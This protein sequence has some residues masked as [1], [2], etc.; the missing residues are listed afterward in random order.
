M[1]KKNKDKYVSKGIHNSVS[2]KNRARDPEPTLF[3]KMRFKWA[4]FLK[5]RKVY[6]TIPNP[7]KEETNKRF[8]RV[9]ARTLYGDYRNY[10]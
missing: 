1:A 10:R 4:A 3:E 2:K 8:I 6:Y 5:G 7:N 9:E